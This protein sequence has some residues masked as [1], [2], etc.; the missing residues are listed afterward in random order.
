MSRLKTTAVLVLMA[1][2]AAGMVLPAAA[3]SG[4]AD[5]TGEQRTESVDIEVGQQLSTVASAT[6][7]EVRSEADQAG[8]EQRFNE[9]SSTE[10]AEAIAQRA[11]ELETTATELRAEYDELTESYRNGEID[12]STF[13][14]RI[15]SLTTKANA[16]EGNTQQLADYA[17]QL[18]DA[19]QRAFDITEDDFDR[20][21][22]PV[23]PISTRTTSAILA[24]YTAESAGEIEIER[25]NGIALEVTSEDGEQS[26]QFE[27]PR[28][29]SGSYEL[30]QSEALS[31]ATDALSE[32]DGEWVLT[33][34][35]ADDGAYEFEFELH[36]AGEGEAEVAV[37]GETGTM[38]ELEESLE[39]G[40]DDEDDERLAIRVTDGEPAPG[41][42]VTLTVTASGEPVSDAT[43]ELD[44]ETVG[45]TGENGT[46]TVT[47]PA[48][49]EAKIEVT[50]GEREGELE[51]EFE[52]EDEEGE[53]GA[54]A[55]I[56]NGTVTVSVLLDGEPVEGASVVANEE[57]VGLTGEDGTA[58]F[59][60]P[61]GEELEIDIEYQDLEAELEYELEAE[62]DEE[63]EDEGREL[64]VSVTDGEP[65]PGEEV[66]LTVTADGEVVDG[67]T[68]E[69]DGEVVGETGAEGTITV[70]L[71]T[72]DAE[73]DVT[74]GNAE[75]ELE[76]EFEDESEDEQSDDDSEDDDSEDDD[77]EDDDSEDD[78]SEDDDDDE[79]ESD[80]DDAEDDDDSDDN[81]E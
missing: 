69:L 61:A 43:V 11:D 49:E 57:P 40:D 75:G 59:S 62:D 14:Q 4:T 79:E 19:E 67:A 64:D 8:F 73:I 46:I 6:T 25:E 80:E 26:R 13:A 66:T 22:D 23:S 76:F 5:Q 34:A 54:T 20:I 7:D 36:G 71:P 63:S 29:G 33:S 16:V 53:L 18:P 41:E 81:D 51:F 39:A 60:L 58:S 72:E 12:G 68:V 3:M 15:A 2:V 50:A 47:L 44:E 30:N 1:A 42:E 24:Q 21:T 78:D 27:R 35:S 70:T 52:D 28:D 9:T 77:S 48:D 37:D 74:D 55:D 38:F 56:D 31:I 65:A 17:A 10:R 32:Q 45:T